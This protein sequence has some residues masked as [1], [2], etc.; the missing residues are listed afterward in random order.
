MDRQVTLKD[1]G[2][3]LDQ[4][5]LDE[6]AAGFQYMDPSKPSHG[7][8]AT[9]ATAAKDL[10]SLD[11]TWT[12][13]LFK[14]LDPLKPLLLDDPSSELDQ[15][16]EGVDTPYR[17]ILERIKYEDERTDYSQKTLTADQRTEMALF[18]SFK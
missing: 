3:K 6:K 16:P 4:F 8:N 17:D 7:P 2:E 12:G 18:H 5:I 14:D 11:L 15:M 13:R 10:T 1:I 9:I